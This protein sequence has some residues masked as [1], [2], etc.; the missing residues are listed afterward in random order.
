MAMAVVQDSKQ[1]L[2]RPLMAQVITGILSLVLIYHFLK[3]IT[4]LSSKL[5][6]RDIIPHLSWGH[7]KRVDEWRGENWGQ[8]CNVLALL[9]QFLIQVS[10]SFLEVTLSLCR[11]NQNAEACFIVVIFFSSIRITWS[12]KVFSNTEWYLCSRLPLS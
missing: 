8:S 3:Q 10:G 1:K 6:E 9:S 2:V 5:R 12:I 4:Y 7:G 11:E